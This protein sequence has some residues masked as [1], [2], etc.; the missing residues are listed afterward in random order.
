MATR[1]KSKTPAVR[2]LRYE[3]TN[4]STPGTETSHYI[5]LARDLSAINRRL[6]RQGRAYH[7]KRISIVSSN[8]I[9]G[10]GV[11]ETPVTGIPGVELQQNA[12]RFTVSCVPDSWTVRNAWRRGFEMWNKMNKQ[13]VLG[14]QNTLKPKFHDF[15]IRGIGSYAPTPTYETPKDNGGGSLS[16]GEWTYSQMVSPDGTTGADNFSLTLLGSHVGSAGSRTSVSLV[17]SYAESRATVQND[18]PNRSAVDIDDPLLNLFDDGTV[19][20][21]IANQLLYYNEDTPYDTDT[22]PGE[23]GN[24]PQPL[25]VQQTTLGAD[26]R[27]TVGGFTAICGLL[28]F[29]TTSPIA[30][31]VYSV[32]VELGEG[33]YRGV[34]AEVI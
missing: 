17:K 9:A 5:D 13:S 21:E 3:L 31:D 22:Y 4:S 19:A 12:G 26:G 20:D 28:E 1:K 11:I 24:M 34:A 6:Y 25:V 15:K 10:Y 8:T 7:V 23:T 2:Y 33:A 29:E 32:L 16:L 18:D 14:D 30:D 27:A